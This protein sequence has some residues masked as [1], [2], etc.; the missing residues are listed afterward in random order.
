MLMLKKL[1][2]RNIDELYSSVR[3][4]VSKNDT[5][6]FSKQIVNKMAVAFNN[7]FTT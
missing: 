4:I 5:F 3:I 6:T 1:V 7:I 2:S